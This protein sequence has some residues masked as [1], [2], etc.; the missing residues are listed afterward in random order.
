MESNVYSAPESELGNEPNTEA[1][2]ASRWSRLFA[3]IIDS[4]ILAVLIVPAFFLVGLYDT[5][6]E[7]GET[8]FFENI[9]IAVVSTV[10]FVLVN[11]KILLR[12]GQT[13]GKKALK[14]KIVSTDSSM[15]SNQAIF[16][17]YGFYLVVQHVPFIGPFINLVNVLFIFSSEKQC[18]HDRI[19]DT[20]VVDC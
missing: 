10:I 14:I 13:W 16:K 19:A 17:R 4:L 18:L 6:I 15:A 8:S 2:L 7:T 5:M 3:S 1:E 11:G 12:D 20:K 9:L